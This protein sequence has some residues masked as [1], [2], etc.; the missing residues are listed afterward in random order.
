MY[1]NEETC[2]LF[3]WGILQETRFLGR[4][5]VCLK[6]EEMS[7]ILAKTTAKVHFNRLSQSD[8]QMTLAC[9]IGEQIIFSKVTFEFL[10]FV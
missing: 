10:S 2:Y 9:H 7:K 1:A 5:F 8:R 3:Y 6:G 4:K